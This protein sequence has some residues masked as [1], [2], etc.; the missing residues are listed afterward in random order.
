[1]HVVKRRN[2]VS[3]SGQPRPLPRLVNPGGGRSSSDFIQAD[4]AGSAMQR[5]S[6]S[7]DKTAIRIR[8][9]GTVVET[10]RAKVEEKVFQFF[11]E[12]GCSLPLPSPPWRIMAGG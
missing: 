6:P 9:T 2:S 8:D 7:P 1:M 10:A 5:F 11:R 12:A 3:F 4:T